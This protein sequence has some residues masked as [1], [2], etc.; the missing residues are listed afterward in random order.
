MVLYLYPP[1]PVIASEA[2]QSIFEPKEF[3]LMEGI[4]FGTMDCRGLRPRSDGGRC[5]HD[6][7]KCF[8]G[9]GRCL[10][11]GE[12][13]CHGRERCLHDEIGAKHF[14]YH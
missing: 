6:G 3:L 5:L 9:G 11:D 8:H 7:E 2:R 13:C 4:W 12:K 10:H 1:N 14:E